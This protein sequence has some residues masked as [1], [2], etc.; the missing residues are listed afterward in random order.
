MSVRIYGNTTVLMATAQIET[1]QNGGAPN[2]AHLI[3]FTPQYG[4]HP[5]MGI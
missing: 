5:Q 2:P 1:T 3:G 4:T